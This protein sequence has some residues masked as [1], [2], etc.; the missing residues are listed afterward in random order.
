M[1]DNRL[2]AILR[3]GQAIALSTRSL[4][5][6]RCGQA[7]GGEGHG[8][9]DALCDL[10]LS[11]EYPRGWP[12]AEAIRLLDRV[13]VDRCARTAILR[14]RLVALSEAIATLDEDAALDDA[15]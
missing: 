6:L 9:A 13:G 3:E 15:A 2:A 8:L 7:V 11:G 12:I 10:M 4:L 1:S 14:R 5:G